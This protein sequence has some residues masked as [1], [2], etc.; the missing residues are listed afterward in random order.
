MNLESGLLVI[1]IDNNLTNF[2]P[3]ISAPARKH[4]FN[5]IRPKRGNNYPSNVLISTALST[6]A[7]QYQD[8][9]TFP[10]NNSI[11]FYKI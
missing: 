9:I 1:E 6:M 8:F 3:F 11:Y 5:P 10:K 7:L 2:Y 4:N